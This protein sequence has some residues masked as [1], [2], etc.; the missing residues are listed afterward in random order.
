[1][2]KQDKP[3][4]GSTQRQ[5]MSRSQFNRSIGKQLQEDQSHHHAVQSHVDNAKKEAHFY[6]DLLFEMM[7]KEVSCDNDSK[8][9]VLTR[10]CPEDDRMKK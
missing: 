5:E 7:T 4:F 9:P 1:M 2:K 3:D 8:S 6:F 10:M